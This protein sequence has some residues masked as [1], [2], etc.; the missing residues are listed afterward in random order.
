MY[1][2]IAI[3][4]SKAANL[5]EVYSLL[6]CVFQSE[7]QHCVH[8]QCLLQLT[9]YYCVLRVTLFTVNAASPSLRVL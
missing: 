4:K 7:E 1:H 9:V 8:L 3:I 5:I 2:Q 6:R